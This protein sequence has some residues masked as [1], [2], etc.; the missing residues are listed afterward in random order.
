MMWSLVA[1]KGK[2]QEGMLAALDGIEGGSC[3]DIEGPGAESKGTDVS[4]PQA[5]ESFCLDALRL[6]WTWNAVLKMQSCLIWQVALTRD[7]TGQAPQQKHLCH[8]L[9]HQGGG[10]DRLAHKAAETHTFFRYRH[11]KKFQPISFNLY[12][13][14]YISE[15][16]WG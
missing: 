16:I 7:R 2:M 10:I 13:S 3:W 14:G 11:T 15:Q 8:A 1:K 12:L 4:L 9:K 5:F 6:M